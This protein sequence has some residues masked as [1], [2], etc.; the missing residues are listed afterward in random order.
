MIKNELNFLD[1]EVYLPE[2]L[3]T[4]EKWVDCICNT[5]NIHKFE[6]VM[7]KLLEDEKMTAFDFY[8]LICSLEHDLTE[9]HKDEA[10]SAL[11]LLVESLINFFIIKWNLTNIKIKKRVNTL[12]CVFSILVN[13]S[14]AEKKN[15]LSSQSPSMK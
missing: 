12:R 3:N 4:R 10:F 6:E 15:M 2:F 5:D 13:I 11:L 1:D 14:C 7:K 8:T 9:Q